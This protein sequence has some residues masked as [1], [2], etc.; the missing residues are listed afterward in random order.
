MSNLLPDVKEDLEA[1]F[2]ETDFTRRRKLPLPLVIAILLN[3]V[4]PGKR[5]GY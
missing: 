3:M 5:V 2:N 4:R 1:D